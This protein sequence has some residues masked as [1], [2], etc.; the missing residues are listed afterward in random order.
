MADVFV[1]YARA[2]GWAARAIAERIQQEGFSVW[3]DKN[4]SIG[5]TFDEELDKQLDKARSV[6]VLWSRSS[7]KSE[8]VL[9]EAAE[10]LAKKA[11]FP[12]LLEPVRVPFGYRR[13][14]TA[15]L[16]DWTPSENHVGLD[17][18]TAA[19]SEALEDGVP[20][21][22]RED[23]SAIPVADLGWFVYRWRRSIVFRL[24]A[25]ALP[26]IVMG[27]GAGAMTQMRVPTPVHLELPVRRLAFTVGGSG[28]VPVL[29]PLAF[30]SLR[31]EHFNSVKLSPKVMS[32]GVDAN[33]ETKSG[34]G[35]WSKL[36]L[37]A[38]EVTLTARDAE[39]SVWIEPP[40]GDPEQVGTLDGLHLRPGTLVTLERKVRRHG[41]EIAIKIEELR[42]PLTLAASAANKPFRIYAGRVDTGELNVPG[43]ADEWMFE[44]E[45]K[46]SSPAIG[47][48]SLRDRLD[49][50]LGVAAETVLALLPKA[51]TPI[52]QVTLISQDAHRNWESTLVADGKLS[53]PGHPDISS[54]GLSKSE[55][56]GLDELSGFAITQLELTPG[57]ESLN[58]HLIGMARSIKTKAGEIAHDHRLTVLEI[59]RSKAALVF[60]ATIICGAMSAMWSAFTALRELRA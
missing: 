25:T 15:D 42:Q 35:K 49:L 36:N 27:V 57:G 14:Q 54:V 7:V 31:I 55:L 44:I 21:E 16:T 46:E 26:M 1:S 18:L 56:I 53:F 45:N 47:I 43:P 52:T 30:S 22:K 11:L 34:S 9:N 10:G 28:V 4:I 33:P 50:G 29:E 3:W 32:V 41:V 2:D 20:R 8:W 60:W 39:S 23:E 38:R 40:P 17:R 6:V 13:V 51:G 58:L 48:K 19:L 24:V 37:A 12:V 5:E 59:Y